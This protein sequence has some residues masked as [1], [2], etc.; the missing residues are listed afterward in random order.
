MKKIVVR[1]VCVMLATF[2]VPFC[3]KSAVPPE[4]NGGGTATPTDPSPRAGDT[5]RVYFPDR[6]ETREMSLRDYIVGV[7]AAE[8]PVSFAH[9]ALCAQALAS[10]TYALYQREHPKNELA[11][12]AEISTDP[13]VYQ[14]FWTVEEMRDRWGDDFEDSYEKICRAVDEVIGFEIVYEDEPVAA[15]FHAI[16]PGR[17]ESAENVWGAQIPYLVSVE[18]AGDSVSPKYRSSLTVN[19]KELKAK[20][21]LETEEAPEDWFGE[22]EYSEAGTLLSAEI[23][24]KTFTGQELRKIL[25]LQSAAFTVDCDGDTF[26]FSVKGYGHG[27]GLSQYGADY[28]ARQ[29]LT[30]REILAHYYPGTSVAERRE[31]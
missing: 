27:V 11:G 30:W 16:S 18:S 29:G 1:W 21:G 15:A 23:A 26:T 3:M 10:L 9:D 19:A 12:G 25:G 22:P 24:G 6:D 28:Y 13:A 2:L 4:E 5:I 14:A 20:L 7:T 17:T 8:M 31:F